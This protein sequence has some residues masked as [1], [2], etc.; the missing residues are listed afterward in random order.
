MPFGLERWSGLP[1]NWLRIS[2]KKI[3]EIRCQFARRP[4]NN[5]GGGKRRGKEK[6]ARLGRTKAGGPGG[7][8]KNESQ[9]LNFINF[10]CFDLRNFV[11]S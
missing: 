10:Y 11:I 1:T 2:E 5:G 3:R 4:G 9:K 6:G 8:A 7:A